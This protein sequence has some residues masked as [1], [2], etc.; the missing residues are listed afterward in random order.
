MIVARRIDR[1]MA[2]PPE[3]TE[4]SGSDAPLPADQPPEDHVEEQQP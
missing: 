1:F 2:R 3:A 4:A